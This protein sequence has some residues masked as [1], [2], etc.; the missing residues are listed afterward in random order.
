MKKPEAPGM[1]LEL[2]TDRV[3]TPEAQIIQAANDFAHQLRHNPLPMI[4]DLL[5][6][7]FPELSKKEA[8]KIAEQNTD[9]G[10]II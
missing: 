8:E 9:H 7:R 2:L 1:R 5:I 3:L 6:K 10:E 4:V